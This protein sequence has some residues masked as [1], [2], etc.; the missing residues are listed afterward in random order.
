M[1]GAHS[2]KVKESLLLGMTKLRCVSDFDH[3]AKRPFLQASAQCVQHMV[4]TA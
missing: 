4:P 2:A 3:H 1:L